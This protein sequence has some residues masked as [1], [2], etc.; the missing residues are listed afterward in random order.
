MCGGGGG[1]DGGA[2]ARKADEEARVSAAVGKVNQ[3]FGNVNATPYDERAKLYDTIKTDANQHA[4]TDL[5]KERNVTERNLRFDVARQ[6][7]SGGSH[8]IDTMRDVTDTYQKGVLRASELA[9]SVANNARASDE[10]T[11]TGLISS[12]RAGLDQGGAVN[13]AY[14]ELRSNADRAAS[15]SSALSLAGFFDRLNNLN[16]Q[17]KYNNGVAAGSLTPRATDANI[18]QPKPFSG[19]D[20]AY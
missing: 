2:A 15:D 6:G 1:G 10:K 12:I 13:Q 3:I 9:S 17:R 11:R 19:S 5:N 20:R 4:L 16:Q 14:S 8:D 18:Q 7:L